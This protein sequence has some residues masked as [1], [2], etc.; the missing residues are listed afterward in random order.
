MF[1]E[2]I[3]WPR[4]LN[5]SEVNLSDHW[6]AIKCLPGLDRNWRGCVQMIRR[7]V[8]RR[9]RPHSAPHHYIEMTHIP[10]RAN[11]ASRAAVAEAN[12]I[13]MCRQS[14]QKLLN[15]IPSVVAL[16]HELYSTHNDA[17]TARSM[18]FT[19]A[20]LWKS[21]ILLF[22]NIKS[23]VTA[24]VSHIGHKQRAI[25]SVLGSGCR[26]VPTLSKVEEWLREQF[27]CLLLANVQSDNFKD[28]KNIK[29][30]SLV[31]RGVGGRPHEARGSNKLGVETEP[32]RPADANNPTQ[33]KTKSPQTTRKRN[34][35]PQKT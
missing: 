24:S 11:L 3:K 19:T 33:H 6:E 5:V 17:V 34:S 15:N 23:I 29:S 28:C 7:G 20:L 22:F 16:A 2:V 13:Q 25:R 10:T 1:R 4:T 35:S 26:H 21:F 9:T 30:G 12:R 31:G 18:H 14:E 32:A 8:R 27:Y